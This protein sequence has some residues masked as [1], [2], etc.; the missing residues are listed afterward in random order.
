MPA[1]LGCMEAV[2]EQR[3][4]TS[5]FISEFTPQTLEDVGEVVTALAEN[6]SR[7]IYLHLPVNNGVNCAFLGYL[8]NYI[9]KI[10]HGTKISLVNVKNKDN[11]FIHYL[12]DKAG[13]RGHVNVIRK[14]PQLHNYDSSIDNSFCEAISDNSRYVLNERI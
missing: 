12:I 3:I 13:L 14:D 4:P 10:N 11:D 5:V 7:D 6:G 8:T 1:F 9:K 2:K